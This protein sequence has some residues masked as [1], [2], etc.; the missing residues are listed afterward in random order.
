MITAG[1]LLIGRLRRER[2]SK[3]TLR[4]RRVIER[5]RA[6][7]ESNADRPQFSDLLEVKGR[8]ARIRL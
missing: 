4:V 5:Q 1:L 8:M 7:V 2:Q 6:V 3:T